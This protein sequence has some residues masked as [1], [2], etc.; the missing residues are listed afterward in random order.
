MPNKDAS[1]HKQARMERQSGQIRAKGT[2]R[3]LC[4][5]RTDCTSLSL[6]CRG[7]L[8]ALRT[9]RRQ[10]GLEK[11]ESSAGARPQ[12][13]ILS[14][15]PFIPRRTLPPLSSTS[16][17]TLILFPFPLH[18]FVLS[19]YY[20][21]LLLLASIDRSLS[22]LRLYLQRPFFRPSSISPEPTD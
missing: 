3:C 4:S 7:P 10:S 17:T 8:P 13:S 6:W 22:F 19:N 15:F 16:A 18:T 14:L 12:I 1:E 5:G 9:R 20:T 2:D 11:G 21:L